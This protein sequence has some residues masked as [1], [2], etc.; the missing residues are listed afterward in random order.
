M[1]MLAEYHTVKKQQGGPRSG[2]GWGAADPGDPRALRRTTRGPRPPHAPAG[3]FKGRKLRPLAAG[4]VFPGAGD[5]APQACKVKKVPVDAG[6]GS[7]EW[8]TGWGGSPFQEE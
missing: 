5:L 8:G 4:G 7:E 1:Q 3:S 2:K 6:R